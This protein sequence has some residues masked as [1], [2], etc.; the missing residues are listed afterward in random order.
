LR[1][2]CC[3]FE[4]ALCWHY[5]VHHGKEMP[6]ARISELK[7]CDPVL[8]EK[9]VNSPPIKPKI[10]EYVD[11]NYA[12][13]Y[14]LTSGYVRRRELALW[15]AAKWASIPMEKRKPYMPG[16]QAKLKMFTKKSLVIF[17]LHAQNSKE[18]TN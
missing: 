4:E 3:G 13:Q 18:A 14:N 5:P 17:S 2:P 8:A 6:Y 16:K 1:C 15:K 12:Y 7:E 10:K 11:S 9:I